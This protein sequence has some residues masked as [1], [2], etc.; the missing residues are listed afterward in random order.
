MRRFG[1]SPRGSISYVPLVLGI[2]GVLAMLA[3]VD[4]RN[5][6]TWAIVI[7]CTTVAAVSYAAY[8]EQ[9]ANRALSI[10]R[11]RSAAMPYDELRRE[12]DRARRHE[13]PFALARVRLPRSG[14]PSRAVAFPHSLMRMTWRSTD[15][16]WRSGRDLY[17]L[18]PET[19]IA[20]AS[21]VLERALDAETTDDLEIHIAAFPDSGLT[22]GALFESLGGAAP[23]SDDVQSGAPVP[24]PDDA[25]EP[26]PVPARRDDG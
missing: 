1:R 6:R 10:V 16:A 21:L 9:R 8:Q 25:L 4:D 19:T 23:R 15:R 11:R 22:V 20:S 24:M 3:L 18:L 26:V 14:R 13:R 12:M 7:G 17:L 5:V 2:V